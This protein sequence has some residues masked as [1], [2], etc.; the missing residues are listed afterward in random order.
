MAEAPLQLG[1]GQS[2]QLGPGQSAQMPQADPL[3]ELR[4]IHMPQFM[5]IW[6]PAIGWWLLVALVLTLLIYGGYRLYRRWRGN[7]Y[8]REAIAELKALRVDYQSHGDDA[9][10]IAG[11]QALLKR[12]A[13]TYYPRE[14]VARLTG[15]SW[16]AFLDRTA[17]SQKFSMGKGQTLIDANYLPEP[18]ADIGALHDLGR[19]WIKN[20]RLELAA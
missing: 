1:P 7:R 15:E 3:A 18:A 14:D 6:P 20:H 10:Y 8:R 2:A 19:H 9:R 16:V 12:V 5:D 11:F 17:R 4:D 13:L